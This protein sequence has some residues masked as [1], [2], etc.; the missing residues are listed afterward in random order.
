M[1][2]LKSIKSLMP[3]VKPH[4]RIG[5]IGFLILQIYTIL[6]NVAPII[7]KQLVEDLITRIS[8][9]KLMKQLIMFSLVWLLQPVTSYL[10]SLMIIRFKERIVQELRNEFF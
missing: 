10:S 8:L 4:V 9:Q 2:K 5:L 1:E 6:I 3:F 7:S